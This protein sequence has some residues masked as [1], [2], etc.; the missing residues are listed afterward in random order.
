MAKERNQK[1]QGIF[2][3]LFAGR[4][5]EDTTTDASGLPDKSGFD[6]DFSNALKNILDNK[7]LDDNGEYEKLRHEFPCSRLGLYDALNMM[8]KDPMIDSAIKMHIAHAL[9]AKTDTNEIIFIES[10][11]DEKDPIV[12]DLRNSLQG[13]L[14]QNLNEWAFMAAKYGVAYIRPYGEHGKGITHIRHDYYTHPSFIREYERAGLLCGFTSKHQQAAKKG[15]ICLMDPWKLVTFKIPQKQTSTLVEPIRMKHAE[16]DLDRDDYLNEEPIETQHYGTSLI[17]TAFDPWSDLQDAILALKSARQNAGKKDRFVTVNTGQETPQKAAKYFNTIANI[18]KRKSE[19]STKR[20]ISKGYYNTVDNI[21]MPVWSSGSGRVEI[22]TETSDVNISSIEDVNFHVNR[23]A[24]ALGVD[25]SL[26]GFTDELSGG[27]GDGGFFR[28]SVTAAIKANLI[29]RAMLNGIQ[30]LC[31]IHVAYKWGK[32]FPES[33]K[34][35]RIVFN[36]LSTAMEQ[37]ESQARE[38]RVNFATAVV[39]LMQQLDPELNG[40]DSKVVNNWVF[41]DLLKM[42]EEKFKTMVATV[43]KQAEGND[44]NNTDDSIMDSANAELSEGK[45]KQIFY[46]CFSE[47][48]GK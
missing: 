16:F 3:R 4:K 42:N 6:E 1:K 45:I 23:L 43:K 39:A 10:A 35:W 21:I 2:K 25:K 9:S 15:M 33:D 24:S 14:N 29:R 44:E 30:R 7:E 40:F 32:V 17:S 13:I 38:S 47:V 8:A 28:V 19:N 36:S 34:P 20:A 22:Q 27:L 18:I 12:E 46:D 26:L 48:M 31:E 37:E 5:E 41:T 11:T